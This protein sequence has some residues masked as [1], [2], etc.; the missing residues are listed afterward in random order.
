[1]R[2]TGAGIDVG[3]ETSS[4]DVMVTNESTAEDE[5]DL[6]DPDRC[7][8]ATENIGTNSADQS[9]GGTVPGTDNVICSGKY[10]VNYL[11]Y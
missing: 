3:I 4:H 7:G 10:N 5:D 11:D 6:T 2:E 9:A 1:M 8:Y